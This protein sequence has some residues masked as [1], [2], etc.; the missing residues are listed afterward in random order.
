MDTWRKSVRLD[1]PEPRAARKASRGGALEGAAGSREIS[2]RLST[3]AK[4]D[5]I[6]QAAD[7]REAG[8]SPNRSLRLV[9]QDTALSRRRQ[10]FE[11][12][13]ERQFRI[14]PP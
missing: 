13:R 1:E 3:I 8:P 9:A 2:W 5:N 10:G 7:T 11:S 12:P 4:R 14:P 6:I